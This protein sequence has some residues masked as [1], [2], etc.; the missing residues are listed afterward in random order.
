MVLEEV[1]LET[2]VPCVFNTMCKTA[3]DIAQHTQIKRVKF[4]FNDCKFVVTSETS[5]LELAVE[6][7]RQLNQVGPARSYVDYI[8]K[9]TNKAQ[10][11]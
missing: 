7:E 2:P 5:S 8:G 10:G 1:V 3:I 6:Y 9:K 4:T 11:E